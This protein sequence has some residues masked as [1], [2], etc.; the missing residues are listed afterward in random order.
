ME[1]EVAVSDDL[2]I[3]GTENTY[4]TLTAKSGNRHFHI[5]SGTPTLTLKWLNMTGGSP[6]SSYGGSIYIDVEGHR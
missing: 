5:G 2:S 3:T 1:D 6:T 4:T